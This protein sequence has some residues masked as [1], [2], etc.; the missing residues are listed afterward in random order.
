MDRAGGSHHIFFRDGI[1]E[2]LNLQPLP[3]GYAK[4]YQ[5]RQAR[6]VIMQYELAA[7]TGRER[8]DEP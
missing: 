3:G 4:P 6:N 7:A 2:I 8:E 1:A 5:V